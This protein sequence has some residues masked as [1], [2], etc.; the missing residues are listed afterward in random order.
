MQVAIDELWGFIP[1][2]F[3]MDEV[4][5]QLLA[6]GIG[7]DASALKPKW[8]EAVNA[9]LVE[10]TLGRPEDSWSVRGSREGKHSEHLGFLLA[11]MQFLQRA[12][13]DA[14]W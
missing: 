4:D 10:A 7:V 3:D 11:E 5:A 14:K 8:D 6:D 13:P 12:Y 2:M 1:E 9:V